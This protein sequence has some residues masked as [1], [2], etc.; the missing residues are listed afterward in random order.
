MTAHG[1]NIRLAA[2]RYGLREDSI[3]DFSAN[4]NPLGLTEKI[5]KVLAD[6]LDSIR[7]YPDPECKALKDEVADFLDLQSR[8]ILIGNG[9]TELI[10]LIPKALAPRR[11]LIVIPTFSEYESSAKQQRS[12]IIFVRRNRESCF[13]MEIENL[14]RL[15]PK[16]GL[17]FICN[18]NNPT[19]DLLS[20]DEIMY[21]VKVARRQGSILIIDEAFIEFIEEEKAFSVVREAAKASNLLV[22]RS[23][24]KFF[25][26]PGLRLGY[27]VGNKDLIDRLSGY[28]FPWNV[29]CLAQIAGREVIKDKNYIRQSKEFSIKERKYLFEKL[30]N[31]KGLA[32]YLPTTNFIFCRLEK[33]LMNSKKLCGQLGS[34]GILVRDCGN[35]RGLNDKYIRIAVRK[36]NENGRLITAL[37]RILS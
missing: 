9:S 6:S 17:V 4:I 27:A 23:L 33:R 7:N 28:Q 1:G 26:L 16:S 29:N 20:K 18:P 19:G 10:Y 8:H 21:L 13:K 5:K 32:P 12:K 3:L 34:R 35:F 2:E 36:R 11:V 14:V 25:A 30:K 37:A 15:V 22:L 31:I 24:T